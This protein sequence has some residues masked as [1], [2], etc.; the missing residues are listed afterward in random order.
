MSPSPPAAHADAAIL[1]ADAELTLRRCAPPFS[2]M[3]RLMPRHD[4][5]YADFYAA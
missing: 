3:T 1:R 2:A 5:R 4:K